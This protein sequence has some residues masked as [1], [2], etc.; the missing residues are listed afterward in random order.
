MLKQN[1]CKRLQ[2]N[3]MKTYT[4]YCGKLGYTQRNFTDLFYNHVR[5]C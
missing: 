4:E 5:F 2:T 1:Y 3:R